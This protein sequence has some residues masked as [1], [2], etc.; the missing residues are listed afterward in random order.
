MSYPE[1]MASGKRTALDNAR[2][3]MADILASHKVD[4]PV[5]AGQEQDVERIL[6]EA[7]EFYR[8]KGMITD[9]EWEAYKEVW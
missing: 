8:K 1:W 7:R 4:P 5:T 2:D 3:I 9:A 6:R